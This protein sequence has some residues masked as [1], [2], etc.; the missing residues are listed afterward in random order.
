MAQAAHRR[1]G[2]RARRAASLS[3]PPRNKYSTRRLRPLSVGDPVAEAAGADVA[4]TFQNGLETRDSPT[5]R[6]ENHD[7]R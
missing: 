7:L 3:R 2:S 4:R 6:W 1:G 5:K